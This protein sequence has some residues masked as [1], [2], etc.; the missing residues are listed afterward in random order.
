MI[1]V[2]QDELVSFKAERQG[3]SRNLHQS[4][5]PDPVFKVHDL[6]SDDNRFFE[7][8]VESVKESV[9]R[10]PLILEE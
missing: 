5:N 6:G 1:A 3:Q 2:L 8:M 7:T 4:S 9:G 10:L